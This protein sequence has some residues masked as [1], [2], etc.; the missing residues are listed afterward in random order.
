MEKIDVKKNEKTMISRLFVY[1]GENPE[2]GLGGS[3][4]TLLL[5]VIPP[6]DESMQHFWLFLFQLAAVLLSILIGS[7][8]LYAVT[9]KVRINKMT[10]KRL[11]EREDCNKLKD[12]KHDAHI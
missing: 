10:L 1:I 7:F 5:S 4:A 2:K 8:T 6:I 9:Q 12:E 3:V 11:K